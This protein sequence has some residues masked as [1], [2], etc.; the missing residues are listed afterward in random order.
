MAV[1]SQY[2][3]T[4][5]EDLITEGHLSFAASRREQYS[6]DASPHPPSMPDVVVWPHTTDEVSRVLAAANDRQIPV[7][8]WSGGSGLE[9]NA[10]PVDGGIVLNTF[11]MKAIDVRPADL[12]A[13]AQAG[14]IYDSLN[15]ALASDGLRFPPGISSGDLATIGGMVATNASGFNSVRYGETRDHVLSVEAV[16]PDGRVIECGRNVIKTSSGY[17]LKDLF[18]GSEGTLGVVTEATL[19]LAGI[20]ER[21]HAALVTFPTI[22]N[23]CQ[24]VSEII[25]YGLRPGAI[26]FIDPTAITL[27]NE[28]SDLGL[29]V[30]P[31]LIIEI[32]ANNSGLDDDVAFAE[33]ICKDNAATTWE[34][35]GEDEMD[36]I[37]QARRDAYE[38][39][40]GYRADWD[41]GIVGDVVVP[42]SKY[43][44][45]ATVVAETS[46]DLDLVCP[47]V[48]HAGDGNLH[49]TP[50]VDP[51][52]SE[53]V[54]RAH[55][56]NERVVSAALDLGGTATGEHGIGTGK[57]KFMARE[58]GP[59]LAVMETIKRSLDPN[60]IMNPGK[61]FPA[62]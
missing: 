5:L 48:G 55:E 52:D 30:E 3:C 25:R 62:D 32:H 40:R 45:I 35:A 8:P 12:Q 4:F 36:E 37:W 60:E 39:A 9:G 7:T 1:D 46:E 26:E 19:G 18:I 27:I 53:M 15:E 47:C 31:T 38:S 44:E 11:E 54:A 50:L 51:D 41:I 6:Q 23:A 59:A 58:H 22:R 61:L 34:S 24:A 57:R 13:T 29:D 49:Y 14:V 42:I 21:K 43:P 56:L 33:S 2:D 20:P 28:Y 10:I 16:L 17:S